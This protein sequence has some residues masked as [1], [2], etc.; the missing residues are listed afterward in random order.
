M[1]E[2]NINKSH[3]YFMNHSTHTHTHARTHTLPELSN[4]YR[5]HS[6]MI[7]RPGCETDY[8]LTSIVEV[9][10]AWNYISTP[11]YTFMA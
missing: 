3:V 6:T 10:D 9:K 4:W 1:Y 8:S 5:G 2:Y 11:P 7:N